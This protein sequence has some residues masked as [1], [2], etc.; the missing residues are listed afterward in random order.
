MKQTA[1]LKVWRGESPEAGRWELSFFG[2]AQ[3][4]RKAYLARDDID[5]PGFY[6]PFAHSDYGWSSY[7]LDQAGNCYSHIC[8]SLQCITS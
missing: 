8:R 4:N 1:K 2:M 3:V 7:L 6:V 5:R